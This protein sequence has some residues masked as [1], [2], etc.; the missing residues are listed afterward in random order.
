MQEEE[1]I[2]SSPI[3]SE[4][5]ALSTY[6]H[7]PQFVEVIHEDKSI[8]LISLINHLLS[9]PIRFPNIKMLVFASDRGTDKLSMKLNE[10]ASI[11]DQI[12]ICTLQSEQSAEERAEVLLG[13]KNGILLVGAVDSFVG[14]KR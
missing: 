13:F 11:K 4:D 7:I 2:H 5:Y 3:N 12:N 14:G 10:T 1:T 6:S 8:P 9:D